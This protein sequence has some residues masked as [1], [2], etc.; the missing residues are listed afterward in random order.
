MI[1]PIDLQLIVAIQEGLA[2]VSRPYALIAEQ[3]DIDEMEVIERLSRLKQ[4]GLIKRLGVIVKHRRLGYQS[5][6]MVVFDIPDDITTQKGQEISQ[7]A[8][9]NLCYL[10]PRQGEQWPYN[11]FCMIHGKS[12]E[13]VLEQLAELIEHCDLAGY[14][15]DILFSP[16]CFKQRGAIYALQEPAIL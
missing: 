12:R 9:I 3:L 11:L 6:A 13:V 7:L 5:N 8:F 1:D 4:Q 10:R 2:V 15:Y 16:R 14:T